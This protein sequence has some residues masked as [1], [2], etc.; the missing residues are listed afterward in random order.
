MLYKYKFLKVQEIWFDEN[1]KI[2]KV[3]KVIYNQIPKKINKH[4]EIFYTLTISLKQDEDNIFSKFRK[5]NRYEIKRAINKD[6]LI[7][8]IY[9]KNIED[10]IL[11]DFVSA[12]NEFGKERGLG[13]IV[14]TIYKSYANNYNLLIANITNKEGDILVWN[15]Y[16][17]YNKRA[18]LKTSNSFLNTQDKDIKNL[19]GRANRMLHWKVM[20]YL[21][22]SGYELYDFGGWYQGNKDIKKLGINNFKESFGGEKEI[23][24]NYTKCLSIK[25]HI[26][27]L[28]FKIKKIIKG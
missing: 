24:F 21:K 12:Y 28:L 3:D 11:N 5:N 4:A 26:H 8:N 22:H 2:K 10:K 19:I 23:S 1:E 25:C 6:K 18:R 16:I 7:C 13:Q 27:Y 9:D 17:L 15:S 14:H 20:L